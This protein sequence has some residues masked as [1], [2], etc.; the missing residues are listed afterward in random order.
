MVVSDYDTLGVSLYMGMG[1]DVK[2]T[3]ILFEL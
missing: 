1:K 3:E 2:F